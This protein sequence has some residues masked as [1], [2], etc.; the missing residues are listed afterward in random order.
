MK[1]FILSLLVATTATFSFG[2]EFQ[3]T[4]TMSMEYEDLPAEMEMYESMLPKENII[5]I[6]NEKSRVESGAMGQTT[7]VITDTKK[8]T[9]VIL[10]NM[11]GQKIAITMDSKDFDSKKEAES[12]TKTTITKETKTIAG[13]KCTKAI[14]TDE[15]GNDSEIWFTKDI[16]AIQGQNNKVPGKID[17]YPMMYTVS[18]GK[19]GTVTMT[20]TK[21]D[22]KTKISDS[23]FET[24]EGYEEMTQEELKQ[25]MGGM[26]Q[27]Q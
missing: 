19:M 26:I 27:G 6:K 16:P 23:E 21:V 8:K 14:I 11:M 15:N 10:M 18:D 4:L 24:P 17:G 20:V 25:M 9:G 3:G 7:I 13:Y 1:K 12:K 5:K 22:T 2:Q